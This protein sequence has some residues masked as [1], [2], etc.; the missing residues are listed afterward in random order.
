MLKLQRPQDLPWKKEE[1]LLCQNASIIPLKQSYDGDRRSVICFILNV[2][3][4]CTYLQACPSYFRVFCLLWRSGPAPF[5]FT[6]TVLGFSFYSTFLWAVLIL[7]FINVFNS[8]VLALGP[9]M[10]MITNNA[11]DDRANQTLCLSDRLKS[12]YN[13]KHKQTK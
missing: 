11:L 2:L 6:C 7:F 3:L 13:P 10:K 4:C 8:M 12:L 5:P 1:S 9:G